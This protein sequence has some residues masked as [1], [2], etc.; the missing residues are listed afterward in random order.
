MNK[1][2]ERR[3][4]GL[5]SRFE[6]A[7]SEIYGCIGKKSRMDRKKVNG[8]GKNEAK[9]VKFLKGIELFTKQNGFFSES[10]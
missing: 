4:A 3:P 5:K 7:D 2:P 10:S 9:R 1:I 6:T 8:V